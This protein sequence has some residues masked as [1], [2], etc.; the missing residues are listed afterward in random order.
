MSNPFFKPILSDSMGMNDRL[1]ARSGMLNSLV[2]GTNPAQVKSLLEL[3]KEMERLRV[4]R[5]MKLSDDMM[6]GMYYDDLSDKATV[7]HNWKVN[8][9]KHLMQY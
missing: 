4:G 7:L 1:L 5:E 9:N 6:R 3:L 8:T 2:K